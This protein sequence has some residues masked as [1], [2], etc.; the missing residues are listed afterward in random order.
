MRNAA[1]AAGLGV[2]LALPA[3]FLKDSSNLSKKAYRYE[4]PYVITRAFPNRTYTVRVSNQLVTVSSLT[5]LPPTGIAVI[6]NDGF[7]KT[8][9]RR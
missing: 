9:S 7:A 1:A 3:W 2:L 4:G 6:T 5:P 8:I